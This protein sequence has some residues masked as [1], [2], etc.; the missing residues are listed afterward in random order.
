VTPALLDAVGEAAFLLVVGKGGVGKTTTAGAV[1][2]ASARAGVPTLLIS[3][4][5]AHSLADLFGVPSARAT[6]LC[7]LPLDF[8][9]F[10]AHAYAQSWSDRTLPDLRALVEAGTYLDADDS[11]GFL[12]LS[13]PGL[14]EVMAAL[15][16]VDLSGGGRRVV[17]DTAPTGHTLRLLGAGR[18]IATWI[19]A[20]DA[21]ALKASV[22]AT[23]FG[24]P[25][26]R[27]V[28]IR[29]IEELESVVRRFESAVLASGAGIV[30][31]RS[32]APVAAET[33][34]LVRALAR[35]GIAVRAV[36]RTGDDADAV[37]GAP[38]GTRHFTV[39]QFHEP[40]RGCDGVGRVADAL[41]GEALA[42][43][44]DGGVTRS[45]GRS[46]RVELQPQASVAAPAAKAAGSAAGWLDGVALRMLLF[47]GKGGV[48]K[49]TCAAAAALRLSRTRNVLLYG[50]DP[51][52][53]LG[54]VL[55]L[56][57]GAEPVLVHQRLRVRQID[58]D[59]ALR[60]LRE[61]YEADL[62]ALFERIGLGGDAALDR[63]VARSLWNLAPPG[64]DEIAALVGLVDRPDTGATAATGEVI[65]LDA[66]PTGHFLRLLQMPE[67]ALDWTHAL[68]RVI[69]KYHAAGALDRVAERLL[70]LAAELKALRALLTDG[71]NAGAVVVTLNEPV[72]AAETAR[73]VGA[74]RDASVPM[75]AAIVNRASAP[76]A[77]AAGGLRGA[78]HIV[79]APPL[80]QAPVGRGALEAFV[81]QWELVA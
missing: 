20:L 65:V 26:A 41:A 39:P 69:L 36:V 6:A 62:D 61:G 35:Q 29:L 34:R 11:R 53:S 74:L 16:L 48:G 49:T 46:M 43:D 24:G 73:L 23:T 80:R 19:A 31:T 12:D 67:L 27:P 54:D 70:R 66:A 15:R 3:T 14:D 52:G 32:G 21:M 75:A 7:D 51:A 72:V 50:T 56:E 38:P 8:E 58:A 77:A 28:A 18:T 2:L 30:V 64:I 63:A 25:A 42:N 9:E 47:A 71:Q 13:L 45:A 1:A 60:S 59:S 68:M 55:G 33:E 81:E 40:P 17:V 5:P 37:T 78:M 57:I 44:R 10:D 76:E 79:A 22:V 4:D